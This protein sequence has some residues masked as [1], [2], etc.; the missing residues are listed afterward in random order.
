MIKR[1]NAK[2]A[3]I[4]AGGF[5]LVCSWQ[6]MA[7]NDGRFG[8]LLPDQMQQQIAVR[9]A[10]KGEDEPLDDPAIELALPV[11]DVVS[12]PAGESLSEIEK[13]VAETLDPISL[14]EKIQQQVVQSELEQFG[15]DLFSTT[16]TTFAPVEGIP[17]PPDYIIGPGDTFLLQVFGP[18]DV[19]YRL[20]VTREGKLLVPEIGD[21]QVAGMTFEEAK[22][23]LRETIARLR[24]GVKAVVTLADLHTIQVMMVGDVSRPGAYTVSGLSSLLNTLITT[25]GIKRSGTLRDVQVRRNGELIARMDIYKVLLSGYD[26]SNIYLRQGDVVFVPPIG[27]TIGVAGE[28]QRPAIYEMRG[29]TTVDEVIALAGGLLPTASP[30]LS[31]IERITDSGLRTLVAANLKKTGGQINVK[32]GDLIRI[33]PVLKKMDQVV[34]LSGHVL[35]PGGYEFRPGMRISD[36]ITSPAQL[37]QSA[38]YLSGMIMREVPASRQF[39][40][41]YFKLD[42][43]INRPRGKG[44]LLMQARDQIFVFDTDSNRA[45]Q[46]QDPVQ[47]LTRQATPYQPPEIFE[48]R[49]FFKH[50][51]KYPLQRGLRLLDVIDI[52]G[53]LQAGVDLDY[54]L[55]F[56][57]DM[58]NGKAEFIQLNLHQARQDRLADHNPLIQPEDRIY[59]FDD[60][61]NRSDLI[62]D[63]IDMIKKQTRYGDLSAIVRISGA[64]MQPGT[65]PLVPGMRLQDLISAAGG[66]REEAYGYSASLTRHEL[67]QGEFSVSDHLDVRLN[68][69]DGMDYDLSL[70]LSAYDHLILR[71]KPEWSDSPKLVTVSGEVT[72]PGKYQVDKRETL[73]GLVRRAGGFTEDAYLF[74]A[75]FTRESVRQREQEAMDKVFDELD[76]VLVDVHI[77][78]GFEKDQKLPVNKSSW[79]IY[80]VLKMLKRPQA[81][82]RMVIDLQTAVARCEEGADFILEDGDKLIVP[83]FKDEVSVAGQVYYPSSHQYRDDRAALDYINL[84]G[85]TRELAKP[86]HAYIMQAN[87]EVMTARQDGLFSWFDSPL[88]VKVTPGSTIF[89]PLS[90]DRINDRE[91]SQSWIDLIYK[92]TLSAASLNYLFND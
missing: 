45:R 39:E 61:T 27:N 34:L 13:K 92:L 11:E 14:E 54:C 60:R 42:D 58:K 40:A 72:Y 49:G 67:L 16:P 76:D 47:K 88:N 5:L 15:Y 55:L 82:G 87:G 53:G 48:T 36:V 20:V 22:L 89:V 90:V 23:T 65:Y 17:V 74:G 86:Q 24:I 18:T 46:L 7:A 33:F 10:P 84:S 44:D 26:D 56:R 35:I 79:D 63:D 32:N 12:E 43:V 75:V 80:R 29:E 37:R 57:K 41:V 2:L 77:S 91:L 4:V 62:S 69:N 78:P 8:V 81:V 64:V 30:E 38:D 68:R 31:H 50:A 85:G 59:L 3:G 71:T 25:G 9:N 1:S 6:V 28:V 73:C 51:G 83:K 66:M 21:I 70:I 19:E 52:T